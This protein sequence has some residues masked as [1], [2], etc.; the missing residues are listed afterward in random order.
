MSEV[1]CKSEVTGKRVGEGVVELQHLQEAL[2][3][4]GVKV[5]VGQGSDVGCR[6]SVRT[7]LPEVVTKHITFTCRTHR[8]LI[9]SK[10]NCN[11]NWYMYIFYVACKSGA[12]LKRFFLQTKIQFYVSANL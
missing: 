11:S 7:L 3:F 5:T 4:D 9:T 1:I 12:F 6:L 8:I 10:I 2:P